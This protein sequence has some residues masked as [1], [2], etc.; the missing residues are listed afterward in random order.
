LIDSKG[1]VVAAPAPIEIEEIAETPAGVEEAAPAAS[2]DTATVVAEVA[3]EAPVAEAD[4]DTP[5]ASE[6]AASE[7]AN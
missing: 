3:T 1:G 5:E 4:P 6:D 7:P 2:D